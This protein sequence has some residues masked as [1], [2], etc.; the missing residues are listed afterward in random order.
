VNPSGISYWQRELT[1]VDVMKTSHT[2]WTAQTHTDSTWNTNDEISLR[3]DGYPASLLV[4][5]AVGTMMLRDLDEHAE[6]GEYMV[7]WDGDGVLKCSLNVISI[8]RGPGWM[9][10]DMDFTT[11]FNNGLFLR[12]EWTNPL[13]PVTNVRVYLPGFDPGVVRARNI[14]SVSGPWSVMPFHPRLLV[15]G[16]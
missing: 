3:K 10:C 1:F 2:S 4:D 15:S 12:I 6:D 8:R 16:R 5:Q 14:T 9:K 7:R 11:E 13:N